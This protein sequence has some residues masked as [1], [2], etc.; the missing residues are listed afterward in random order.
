MV[1]LLLLPNTIPRLLVRRCRICE[2][3]MD[4]V[5]VVWECV[6]KEIHYK[7]LE[8]LRIGGSAPEAELS[9]SQPS[10]E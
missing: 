10:I 9:V 7:F 5:V 2:L 6:P 4:D 3:E 1:V 8:T